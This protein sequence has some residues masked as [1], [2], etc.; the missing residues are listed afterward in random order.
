MLK[1]AKI[2]LITFVSIALAGLTND[3]CAQKNS[4]DSSFIHF[5]GFVITAD[6]ASPIPYANVNIK[7]K[8][9]GTSTNLEGFY[10]L[11]VKKNDTLIFNSI[12]FKPQTFVVPDEVSND[13][14]THVQTLVM[15]TIAFKEAVIQE[16]PHKQKFREA[17]LTLDIPSDRYKLSRKNLDAEK[18]NQISKSL[19]ADAKENYNYAIQQ[20]HDEAF[21]SGANRPFYT[22]PDSET[23]IPGSLLNPL[24]WSKFI[25]SVKNGNLGE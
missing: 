1:I 19:P 3:A 17:F 16:L 8:G 20:I 6:S 13:K 23:P 4:A 21:Y 10:A 14:L 9:R 18:L 15:D 24:A 25:K 11:P 7:S 5:A 2:A 22:S 12:G